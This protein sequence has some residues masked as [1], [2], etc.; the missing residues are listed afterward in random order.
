MSLAERRKRLQE[1]KEQEKNG[2]SGASMTTTRVSDPRDA[3]SKRLAEMKQAEQQERL[4]SLSSELTSRVNTWF[5]NN[6]NY[7]NNYKNRF[8]G[9]TGSY[10]DPYDSDISNWISTVTTQ[11][12]NFDTE[13]ASIKAIIEENKDYLNSDWVNEVFSAFDS[14]SKVQNDIV[15]ASNSFGEYWSQ[16]E[17]EDAYKEWAGAVAEREKL[18]SVDLDESRSEIERLQTYADLYDEATSSIPALKTLIQQKERELKYGHFVDTDKVSKELNDAKMQLSRYEN[19]LSQLGNLDINK[20]KGDISQKSAN[21]TLAE[22]AQKAAEL[23]SVADNAP[24]FGSYSEL[25]K[26]ISYESV[27]GS[28]KQNGITVYDDLKAATLALNEHYSG[29]ELYS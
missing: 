12:S 7:I 23:A 29:E 11:K 28:K 8:S 16:W 4:T 6:E 10:T 18:L 26:S 20:L 27:G 9:V 17:S 2:T 21:L 19:T 1:L 5:K 3:R 15:G 25:G 13:A 22:R 14:A 24:D